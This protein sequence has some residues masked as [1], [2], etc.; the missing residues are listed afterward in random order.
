MFG[1]LLHNCVAVC[2]VD[3]SWC[4][5]ILIFMEMLKSY[6]SCTLTSDESVWTLAKLLLARWYELLE[7]KQSM[8][9]DETFYLWNVYCKTL[10]PTGD[11][12]FAVHKCM[13]VGF[14]F[15]NPA[16]KCTQKRKT[17]WEK[18][19]HVNMQQRIRFFRNICIF[20]LITKDNDQIMFK[21]N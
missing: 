6:K 4:H 1:R 17:S 15:L 5:Q 9:V 3:G 13:E 7:F 2:K 8:I 16:C 14:Q 18:F 12:A 20:T 19:V 10:L 21:E 11:T